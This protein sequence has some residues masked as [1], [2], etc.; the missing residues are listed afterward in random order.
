[1]RANEVLADGFGRLPDL[2]HGVLDGCPRALLTE[3]IDPEANTVA[4]LVWHLARVQDAQLADVAG[5]AQRWDDGGWAQRFALPLPH[6][7][8]G[9][10]H[11][12][13]QVA[14]VTAD[15]QLLAGYADDVCRATLA[16][17]RTLDD[18]ALDRVVDERWDPPVTLGV[19]LVS[20]LDDDLQHVGQAAFLRG[21]LERRSG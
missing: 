17:L 10:G 1:M 4:W 21:V 14:A 3:R 9:Y 11:D 19:R 13:G 20:V 18:A 16:Y 15:A 12:P 5:T 7:D 2:V 8:T 6:D